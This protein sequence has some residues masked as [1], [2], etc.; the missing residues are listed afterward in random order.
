MICSVCQTHLCRCA[1]FLT[2]AHVQ[3]NNVSVNNSA[4]LINM[5]IIHFIMLVFER[6]GKKWTKQCFCGQIFMSGR[7]GPPLYCLPAPSDSEREEN[8]EQR[9]QRMYYYGNAYVLKIKK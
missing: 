9:Q 5:Y 2:H 6:K 1:R 4:S 3:S 7:L 8:F